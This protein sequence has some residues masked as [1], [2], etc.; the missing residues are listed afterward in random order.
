[1]ADERAHEAW[2]QRIH[3]IG[4]P[5]S[6]KTTLASRLAA[7]IGVRPVHLDGIARVGG[8]TGPPRSMEQRLNDVSAIASRPAW[9]TEGVHL[10]WTDALLERADLIVWLDT[11]GRATASRRIVGRFVRDAVAEMRRR[12]GRDRFLRIRDYLRHL[13]DLLGGV[14][15][16]RDYYQHDPDA[17]AAG[18]S[19]SQIMARLSR[20]GHRVIRC[21]SAADVERLVA[22]LEGSR[23]RGQ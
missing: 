6:G 15:E 20:E 13:G 1:M 17:S 19:G 10:G 11:V 2:P 23:T 14:R 5:G 16:T 3:I 9:V 18:A 22:R 7:A 8:G 12:R 4:G 21:R